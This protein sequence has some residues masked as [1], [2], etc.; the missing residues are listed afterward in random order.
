M[1]VVTSAKSRLMMPGRDDQI[2]DAPNGL[3]QNVVGPAKRVHDR[4]LFLDLA[5]L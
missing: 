3:Q 1:T 5:E 4:D 2:G